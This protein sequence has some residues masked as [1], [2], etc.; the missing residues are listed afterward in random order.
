LDC[1]I[2]YTEDALADL[3]E[4]LAYSW[5]QFPETT[6]TFIRGIVATINRLKFFPRLGVP[7]CGAPGV[8]EFVHRP[9]VIQYR[10]WEDDC[11]VQVL[12]LLHVA[13]RR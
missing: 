11:V 3:E 5:A 12:R 9:I 7:I 8:R 4:I 1:K 2:R 13:R 10:L 6:E